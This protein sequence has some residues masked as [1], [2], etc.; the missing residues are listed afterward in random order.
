M[1]RKQWAVLWVASFLF[2]FVFIALDLNHGSFNS[3]YDACSFMDNYYYELY[4]G[5]NITEEEYGEYL[6]SDSGEL[7]EFD[8]YCL[9]RSN[10][11][12]PFIW[13]F[14]GLGWVFLI[15]WFLEPK[16]KR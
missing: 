3:D 9:L 7:D 11:Y 13:L 2:S 16:K 6:T 1:N 8:V 14:F 12:A 4:T 5:G 15:L 10:I